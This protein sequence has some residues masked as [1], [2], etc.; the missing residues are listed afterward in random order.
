MNV[1][2]NPSKINI[3]KLKN[4]NI[5]ENITSQGGCKTTAL[6]A[7]GISQLQGAPECILCS[8]PTPACSK[9]CRAWLQTVTLDKL[10]IATAATQT[11]LI[12]SAHYKYS[13]KKR[14]KNQNSI[15]INYTQ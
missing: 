6:P 9:N 11:P 5:E 13:I 14:I 10:W 3:I 4:K 8:A 1:L 15:N 2:S 12:N 7:T